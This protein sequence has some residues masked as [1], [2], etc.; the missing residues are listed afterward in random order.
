[1]SLSV[2]K[3]HMVGDAWDFVEEPDYAKTLAGFESWRAD[4][5]G[6]P[7]VQAL[8]CRI[9]PELRLQDIYC[10]GADVSDLIQEAQCV[11]EHLTSIAEATGQ[12]RDSIRYRI[13]N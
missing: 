5:W 9:L 12:D 10:F 3:C 13:R 8:G 11:L 6:S 1:M 7:A 2:H 4:V